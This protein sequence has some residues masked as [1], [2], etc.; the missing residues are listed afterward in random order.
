MAENERRGY[1]RCVEVRSEHAASQGDFVR[2]SMVAEADRRRQD[3]RKLQRVE[4]SK[5]SEYRPERDRS[6]GR[7][8]NAKA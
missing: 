8:L 6:V 3:V 5:A 2:Q 7:H 1:S 4:E